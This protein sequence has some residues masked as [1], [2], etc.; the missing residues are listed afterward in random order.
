MKK[1]K[2]EILQFVTCMSL[3]GVMPNNSDKERQTAYDRIYMWNLKK[4]ELNS[5]K[6]TVDWELS[7]VGG[8][9]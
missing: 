5:Q 3:E 2:E 9:E 7:W 8:A 1:K 6:Q 4:R